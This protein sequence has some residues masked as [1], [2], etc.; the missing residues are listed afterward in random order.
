[1]GKMF[2]LVSAYIILW[3]VL[4]GYVLSILKKQKMLSRELDNLKKQVSQKQN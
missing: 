3:A 4:F 2:Y 1:M